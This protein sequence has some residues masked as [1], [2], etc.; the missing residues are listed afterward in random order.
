MNRSIA[1][2]GFVALLLSTR[3]VLAAPAPTPV[4]AAA[5]TPAP[6]AAE[7]P[8]ADGA[9]ADDLESLLASN[10]ISGASRTAEKSDDAPATT[11]TVT[12]D[13][14]RRF[15]IRTLAEAVNFLAIGMVS[16]DPLHSV[17]V[18]SR[19]V[20]LSGDYGNHVL[21][22]LDG[23]IM[24]E[25]WNGTAYFEQGL[26]VPMELIDHIEVIV[27][28]GSVLY[29]S[30]A[31]LGV[32]NVTTKRAKDLPALG[33]A[34][35]GTMSP[36][37][38]A[39]GGITSLTTGA[40][41]SGRFSAVSGYVMPSDKHRVELVI[42]AEYYKHQGQDLTFGLQPT[43]RNFGARAPG[44]AG[45]GQWGGTANQSWW[46]EV[47]SVYARLTIDDVEA[48]VRWA[49][50][51]R[52]TPFMSAFGQTSGSFDEPRAKSGE[53]DDWLNLELKFQRRLTEK[54]RF[55]AR[56]YADIYK[57]SMD[58]PSVDL[59]TD[60]PAEVQTTSTEIRFVQR[61]RSTWGGVELQGTYDWLGDGRHQTLFG[62]D[63][64]LRRLGNS[65]DYYDNLF[66]NHLAGTVAAG[67][68][69]EWLAAPYAQHRAALTET[70][71]V[72]A[73]VRLDAQSAFDPKASPRAAV[74]WRVVPDGVLKVVYSEAFRSPSYYERLYDWPG[75][76]VGNPNL[77]PETVK[78]GELSWEQRIGT[79]RGL[80][81][82]FYQQFRG[83]STSTLLD[84]G[85]SQFQNAGGIASYGG[86][87]SFEETTG[88]LRYGANVTVASAMRETDG[89][90][91]R[92]P[93][94]PSV[95]G[96]ARVLYLPGENIWS[97]PAFSLASSIIGPRLVNVVYNGTWPTRPSVP[98]Q[99]DLRATITGTLAGGL[100]YRLMANYAFRGLSPYAIG[101]NQEPAAEN[102]VNPALAPVNR[103]VMMFGLQYSIR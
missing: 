12:S 47:P 6:A 82:V 54:F 20:M 8:A 21:V 89:S 88:K 50:Y 98:T 23:H 99:V 56:A 81:G 66:P 97:N 40:G 31:M 84:S 49:R 102:P 61:G 28:P 96:N 76:Q 69:V 45:G 77:K 53:H 57:Y 25:P 73:G 70:V 2:C 4:A 11:T 62:I 90:T 68:A 67:D 59:A 14:L 43:D 24:N 95:Y 36:A 91:E 16:Q 101:P 78:A 7:A 44:G 86:N 13:D 72:N 27:G 100:D 38:G 17:E 46:T 32:F 33:V 60:L 42:G 93:V 75:T 51:G 63:T 87:A 58:T 48:F 41:G 1:S 52:G 26:G 18:G 103:L 22:V 92:L 39:N 29:G 9:D 10:V 55:M 30:Y 83:L 3:A 74:V 71:S 5:P 19:G 35:E 37:Q 34:A 79:K 65:N 64:R 15:G 85:V 80:V 94:A